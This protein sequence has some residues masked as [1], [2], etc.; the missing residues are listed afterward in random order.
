[1]PEVQILQMERNAG[2]EMSTPIIS[3]RARARGKV[4]NAVKRGTLPNLTTTIVPCIDCGKR[5]SQYDHRDYR[6]PLDVQPVCLICNC[7]RG[8]GLPL[9]ENPVTCTLCKRSTLLY[10]ELDD[11]FLC[12][13]CG[14]RFPRQTESKVKENG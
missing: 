4:A 8:A 9:D 2:I 11:T 12:R 5:A 3:V 14:N 7:K 1:M 13:G 10:R 6:K